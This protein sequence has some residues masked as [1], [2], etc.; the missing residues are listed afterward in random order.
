MTDFSVILLVYVLFAEVRSEEHHSDT[1]APN[2][3]KKA[4]N[5]A[6]NVIQVGNISFEGISD[7][8]SH[9]MSRMI[10][11]RAGDFVRKGQIDSSLTLLKTTGV[12]KS[13]KYRLEG[14]EAPYNLIF[15]CESAAHNN[16]KIG[17]RADTEEWASL[18]IQLGFNNNPL[19]GSRFNLS[20]KLGQNLK[21]KMH[22]ELD[23]LS[24]P[25][26]N[27]D[28]SA[29]NYRGDLSYAQINGSNNIDV[30]Y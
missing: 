8:E 14:K 21:A 4:V 23:M 5:L 28:V 13:V 20:A 29:A 17:F 25:T 24:W 19:S 3:R 27:L 7:R 1:A 30:S 11:F 6:D 18:L 26:I 15:D 10:L 22:Y 12:L 16:F 9:V 2:I